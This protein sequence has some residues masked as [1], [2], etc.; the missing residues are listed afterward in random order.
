[1]EENRK[2][3][4]REIEFD[5]FDEDDN[6]NQIQIMEA[7]EETEIDVVGLNP[8]DFGS[9]DEEE[10]IKDLVWFLPITTEVESTEEPIFYKPH[11]ST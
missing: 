3:E 5:I 6:E 7:E 2:Y 10:E 9:S 4:E 8:S 1:M 11:T